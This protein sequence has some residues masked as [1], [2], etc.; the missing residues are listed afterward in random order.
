[1]CVCLS[2]DALHSSVELFR[3]LS[4]IGYTKHNLRKQFCLFVFAAPTTKQWP[5]FYFQLQPIKW[6]G[7]LLAAV[8]LCFLV[9]SQQNYQ[10]AEQRDKKGNRSA[11]EERRAGSW[12]ERKTLIFH[13]THWNVHLWYM[14][15]LVTFA[16]RVVGSCLQ[17]QV[18]G[19]VKTA[20]LWS[21]EASNLTSE[22]LD[23]VTWC[24]LKRA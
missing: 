12:N 22:I 13:Q 21:Q 7:S 18:S 16:F 6:Y 9:R 14:N 24:E 2:A 15:I 4:D 5:S 8:S 23:R 19:A 3:F 10:Q 20:I 1:M 17:F 11:R